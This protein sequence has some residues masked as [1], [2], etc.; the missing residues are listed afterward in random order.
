MQRTRARPR[1]SEAEQ[2]AIALVKQFIARINA[3]DPVGLGL[4]S[5]P[6]LRFI[7]ATGTRYSLG[8]P[9]WKRYFS[10]F[11]DYRMTV[12][13]IVSDGTTV[14]I[15]GSARGSFK[16]RGRRAAGAAWHLPVAWRARVRAGKVVE[17]QVY[18]DVEP[19]LQSSGRGRAPLA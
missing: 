6:G 4:L 19:M 16:G 7:D 14:A 15:F 18:C 12:D 11:P 1:G 17:W 10:T 13:G 3:H 5:L 8:K 2:Q 9:G